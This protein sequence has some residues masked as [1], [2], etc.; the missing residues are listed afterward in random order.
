MHVYEAGRDDQSCRVQ[1]L[2]ALGHTF[3]LIKQTRDSPI[4]N[5]KILAAILSLRRINKV[6]VCYQQSHSFLPMMNAE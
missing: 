2:C 1:N 5:Q 6:A 4:F 3:A